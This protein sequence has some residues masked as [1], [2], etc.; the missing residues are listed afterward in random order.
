MLGSQR[1]RHF[2]GNLR[3]LLADN[4][5]GYPNATPDALAS[6]AHVCVSLAGQL[7]FPELSKTSRDLETACLSG[8]GIEFAL[9]EFDLAR[10]RALILLERAAAPARPHQTSKSA[11]AR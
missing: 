11:T 8:S 6:S 4:H 1:V 5:W 9:D 3:N 2:M 10:L 7:G